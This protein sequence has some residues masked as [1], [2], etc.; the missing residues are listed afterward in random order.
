MMEHK[1]KRAPFF[2]ATQGMICLLLFFS[3]ALVFLVPRLGPVAAFSIGLVLAL[4]TALLSLIS[5]IRGEPPR[6]RALF[7]IVVMILYMITM[8]VGIAYEI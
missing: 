5:R 8:L 3:F 2:A 7:L 4:T 1:D 6:L